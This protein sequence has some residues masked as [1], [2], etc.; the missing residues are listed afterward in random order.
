MGDFD[1]TSNNSSSINDSSS[2]SVRFDDKHFLAIKD[3]EKWVSKL[4]NKMKKFDP[5]L[6]TWIKSEVHKEIKDFIEFIFNNSH[7]I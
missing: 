7:I 3:L 6:I 4:R 2:T 5:D 1:S